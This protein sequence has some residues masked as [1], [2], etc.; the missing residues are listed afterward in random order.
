MGWTD[1][2]PCPDCGDTDVELV[3]AED[4]K[5]G[6]DFWFCLSCGRDRSEEN[7]FGGPDD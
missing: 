3:D 7:L 5:T 2:E 4:S 1:A 6:K